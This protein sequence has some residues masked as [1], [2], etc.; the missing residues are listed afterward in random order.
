MHTKNSSISCGI[1]SHRKQLNVSSIASF[2]Y[3]FGDMTI[4]YLK[5]TLINSFMHSTYL[6][7]WKSH[8]SFPRVFEIAE[9]YN[10]NS[11]YVIYSIQKQ[12]SI[13]V[14]V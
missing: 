13:Y 2:I 8:Y 1:G 4:N 14:N 9:L 3:R 7:M 10:R 5:L 11:L 12:D 6:E